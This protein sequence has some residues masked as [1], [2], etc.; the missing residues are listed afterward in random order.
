MKNTEK[1][2]IFDINFISFLDLF[3]FL[4]EDKR[5][6]QYIAQQSGFY[7]QQY[8]TKL[9]QA[10]SKQELKEVMLFIL[11]NI[12]EK[13]VFDAKYNFILHTLLF[14]KRQ[15]IVQLHNAD[16]KTKNLLGQIEFSFKDYGDD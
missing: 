15:C 4:L 14:A 7:T 10:K 6:L 11:E 8:K 5:Y 1:K 9:F 16:D 2:T 13:Y 3:D 12:E